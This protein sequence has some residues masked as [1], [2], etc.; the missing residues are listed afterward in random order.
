MTTIVPLNFVS[1]NTS[2]PIINIAPDVTQVPSVTSGMQFYLD[3][4]WEG[5]TETGQF[6]SNSPVTAWQ[7]AYYQ[8]W[9][10]AAK[11]LKWKAPNDSM[12]LAAMTTNPNS[13]SGW[14][15]L[16]ALAEDLIGGYPTMMTASAG[17]VLDLN[18]RP[19]DTEYRAAQ[20][21]PTYTHFI[22]FKAA[23]GTMGGLL[24]QSSGTEAATVWRFGWPSASN[25]GQLLFQHNIANRLMIPRDVANDKPTIAIIRC[26]E[27]NSGVVTI[28]NNGSR[29]DH[30]FAFSAGFNATE[31]LTIG[32]VG[33][34]SSGT[35]R[36]FALY[37]RYN[38]A[39]EAA[40]VDV[41]VQFAKDKFGAF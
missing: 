18:G 24:G 9:I 8:K 40:E 10:D 4:T 23:P 15:K 5:A 28:V 2:L 6:P 17:Q 13:N 34:G 3:T 37:S 31:N 1:P 33:T 25:D 12:P 21:T 7:G 36:R 38:R 19:T 22:I 41:L 20:N 11:R 16:S 26:N 14:P 35:K 30:P 39:I 29:T 32:G 27:N